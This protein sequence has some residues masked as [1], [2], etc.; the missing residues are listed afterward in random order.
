MTSS[1][2]VVI[3]GA[4]GQ[5]NE[6]A[7]YIERN[8][9][10]VSYFAVGK[11]F[12]NARQNFVDVSNPPEDMMNAGVISAIGAPL[13]RKRLVGCWP[14]RSFINVI[15]DSA[16]VDDSAAILEGTTIGP[17]AFIA[18]DVKIGR[19]CLVNA[20]CSISHNS[21]LG[22]YVTVSPGANIGGNV[23]I[24]DGV[25]VG[26]GAVIKNNVSIAEGVVV[27]AGSLVLEDIREPNSVY[28]GSPAKLLRVNK[29]WLDEIK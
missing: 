13:T 8:G 16:Y 27:G 2:S 6:T 7:S 12:M 10:K 26:M 19:H 21:V 3:I 20:S 14:G 18:P 15:S 4:G 17:C 24:S 5:A 25:F 23:T 11:E 9:G 28:V 29:D 22:D 1:Q